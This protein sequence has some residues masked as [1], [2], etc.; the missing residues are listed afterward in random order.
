MRT[1]FRLPQGRGHRLVWRLVTIVLALVGAAGTF[2]VPAITDA[3]ATPRNTIRMDAVRPSVSRPLVKARAGSR[4][5]PRRAIRVGVGRRSVSRP[6]GKGFI[7]LSIEYPSSIPYSGRNPRRPNPLYI[8]LVRGLNSGQRPVIRFG[9]DTADWTWWPA[10]GVPRPRGIRYTLTR[11]WL[12]VTRATARQLNARLILGVNLEAD[13]PR[14]A[15]T[16]ARALLHGIGRRYIAGFELGNE[17]EVYGSLPWYTTA[18]KV[19]VPGR[20]ASY[21]FAAYLRDYKRVSAALPRT[22]PLVGPASGAPPW[23]TGLHHYLVANP[24]VRMATFHR[25]P[26]HRCFNPRNSPTYPTIANL[27]APV[28]SSGPAVSL[29]AA[30]A[31]AHARGIPFRSDELNSVS[32]GGARGVS[33]TFASSLW[34]LDTL[35]NMARV[36]ADGV[37]IHTF[38]SAAYAPFYFRF[39]HGRWSARVM[40]MY[41]GLLMFTRAAPPG[42]RL[43]RVAYRAPSTLRVWATRSDGRTALVAIND[44]RRHAVT[45]AAR[46]AGAGSTA[47]L[48]RLTAPRAGARTGVSL[49]GQNFARRWGNGQL[50]GQPHEPVLTSVRGR[51]VVRLG[52]ASAILLTAPSG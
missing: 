17:P 22:V 19:P 5:I 24:R 1:R 34:I 12:Q 44:S 25:Y 41:Y 21:G 6:I 29:E 40:P 31:V 32:C 23:L 38:R 7:G 2:V 14:V 35:F 39:A 47:T 52:P 10:R 37:N 46:L 30:I 36:G 49:A 42:A 51:F 13:R 8:E 28:A 27:L 9:G 48:Q 11:R 50:S 16:E 45:I 15:G 33:D 18:A 3:P 20:P 4:A 26:L 43:A